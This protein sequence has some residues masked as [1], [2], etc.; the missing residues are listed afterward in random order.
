MMEICDN[1]HMALTVI[2]TSQPKGQIENGSYASKN[3]NDHHQNSP[4]GPYT[5]DFTETLL[6]MSETLLNM[7]ETLLNKS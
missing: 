6:N 4:E 1:W 7:S 5:S 2:I 3:C